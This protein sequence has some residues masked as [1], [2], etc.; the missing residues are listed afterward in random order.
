[1]DEIVSEKEK[2]WFTTRLADEN[3]DGCKDGNM[4]ESEYPM[5]SPILN[6]K[7]IKYR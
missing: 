4:Q 7:C 2:L 1:V 6:L 5:Y 3:R